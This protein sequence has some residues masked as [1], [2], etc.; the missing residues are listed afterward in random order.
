MKSDQLYTSRM[1][2]KRRLIASWGEI[3]VFARADLCR[4]PMGPS[5]SSPTDERKVTASRSDAP[6]RDSNPVLSLLEYPSR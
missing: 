1:Q 4:D 6:A 3:E 2:L 5:L